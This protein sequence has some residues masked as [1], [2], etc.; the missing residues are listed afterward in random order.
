MRKAFCYVLLAVMP[1]SLLA[2]SP[3]EDYA[4]L[5]AAKTA[6][7]SAYTTNDVETYFSFYAPDATA[8]FG[9][10]VRG[11]IPAYHEMWTALMEAG[12]GV[13]VNELSDIRFQLMPGGE[14]GVVTCFVYNRRREPD[15]TKVIAKAFQTDVWRK[16]AGQ[17]K[18]I[19]LHYSEYP[20]VE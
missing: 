3:G 1:M 20:E 14:V 16:T 5:R 6:F 13:E 11:D 18:I 17:W 7:E 2:E 12:G 8:Y 4:D 10:D 15:G 19:S 9:G